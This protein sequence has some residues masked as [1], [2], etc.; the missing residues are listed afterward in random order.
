MHYLIDGYNWL[1]Q[2]KKSDKEEALKE[3]REFIIRELTLKLSFAKIDATLV[4]DSQFD[5][6][7]LEKMHS[8]G[9]AIYFTECGQTADE[10]II[11][12][13]KYSTK[14]QNYTVV[15]SDRLLA[16][17]ARQRT[18]KSLSISEFKK[19]LDRIVKKKQRPSLEPKE[20]PIKFLPKKTLQ[21]RY[22]EIFTK[23]LNPDLQTKQDFPIIEP[24][25]KIEIPEPMSDYDRWLKAFERET[26]A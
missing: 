4:F 17:N 13:I 8:K 22:E 25:K 9:I 11:E 10:Y 23:N 20:I 2:V 1:F 26:G 3:Q 18:C 19:M 16:W 7:P 14:P 12:L 6:R 15:T 5:I 21:D 24:K